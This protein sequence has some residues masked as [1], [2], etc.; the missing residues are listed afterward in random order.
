MSGEFPLIAEVSRRRPVRRSASG[1]MLR[2]DAER[3]ESAVEQLEPSD[4]ERVT[5]VPPSPSTA[6]PTSHFMESN[7]ET[8]P[9]PPWHD[10]ED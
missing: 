5:E 6:H 2:V 10:E 7:L 3:T 4:S 1:E 9:A 8:I